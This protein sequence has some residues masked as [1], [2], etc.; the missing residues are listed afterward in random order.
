MKMIGLINAEFLNSVSSELQLGKYLK[1]PSFIQGHDP[2]SF[3]CQIQFKWQTLYITD[4][5]VID[6]RT[7]I[8]IS[9]LL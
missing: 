7:C 1:N 3:S 5:S 8:N 2:F 4:G 6:T 9:F